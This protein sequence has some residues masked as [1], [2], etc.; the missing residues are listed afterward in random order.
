M[1]L[2]RLT[3]NDAFSVPGERIDRKTTSFGVYDKDRTVAPF[4]EIKT[5]EW[6]AQPDPRGR[7]PNAVVRF[8]GPTLFAGGVDKQFGFML[9]NSLGRLWALDNLPP[10]T[11]IV[12][13]AKQ[14][15]RAVSYDG[16]CAIIR[17]L[18]LRNPIAVT[19]QPAHF[20]ELHLA[21]ERFG[22]TVGVTGTAEFY[23]W[24]DRRWPPAAPPAPKRKIY[25]TR[26]GLGPNAGRYAGEDHLERLLVAQGY[27][28]YSPEQHGISEQ[29]KTYQSAGRLVFA[30]GSALHL[31]ALIRQPSQAYAVVQRR[32]ELPKGLLRQMKERDGPAPQ[33]IDAIAE[34]W[35]PPHRGEHLGKSVLD[36]DHLFEALSQG[37]FV[38]KSGWWTAPS[39]DDVEASLRAGLEPGQDVMPY[40]IWRSWKQDLRHGR[41]T[42]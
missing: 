33:F 32:K 14:V 29:V 12:F 22:E 1:S 16:L 3:L 7:M 26:S 20:E 39:R 25:V 18:G 5:S 17:A 13:A 34:T 42:A 41:L 10:E 31:F 6:T 28:I 19:K 37:G 27:E 2:T 24:I 4:T 40:D 35:W 23:D 15:K 38:S 21:E 36:F 8:F 9:L 30:E 11:T